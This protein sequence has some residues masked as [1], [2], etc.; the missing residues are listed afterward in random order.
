MNYRRPVILDVLS[1][2][3]AALM[4]AAVYPFLAGLLGFS[5]S[6]FRTVSAA[7]I[8]MILPVAASFFLNR[9]IKSL[10]VF[11]LLGAAI[12]AGCCYLARYWGGGDCYSGFVCGAATAVG[13]AIIFGFRIYTRILYG[14]EKRTFY[15]VHS[16]DTPF[17]LKGR[18][19]PSPLNSPKL[20]H[21]LWFSALYLLGM[22]L[23][24]KTTLYILFAMVFA[25]IFVCL[26]YRYISALYEY[27]RAN[28]RLTGLPLNVMK[29]IHQLAGIAGTLLLALFLLPALLYGREFDP[30]I[31]TR[32][33][34][35]P[36]PQVMQQDNNY[37]YASAM[38]DTE[39]V[40]NS[41]PHQPAPKWIETL[42]KLFGCLVAV[43][44]IVTAAVLLF[45][46]IPSLEKGFSELEEKDEVVFLKRS[47]SSDEKKASGNILR[48]G[49]FSK[50]QQIRRHYRRLIRK[51]TKGIPSS[52]ATPTELERNAALSDSSE[53]K[54]LHEIYEK[55]RYD[56]P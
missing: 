55:A 21:L 29:K 3:H 6:T 36:A 35:T 44:S 53:M 27:I 38:S 54:E 25:D 23:C 39:M 24:L 42:L 41:K 13:T 11:F 12:T 30:K 7:G 22:I 2:V 15:A 10:I 16:A 46:I 31:S 43:S 4:F 47:G 56:K 48:E 49:I 33:P 32:E 9:K 52:S 45:H 28:R 19:L 17:D 8:L 50:R 51:H 1:L 14:K 20:Y 37:S 34:V 26:G 18:E 40:E 5:G